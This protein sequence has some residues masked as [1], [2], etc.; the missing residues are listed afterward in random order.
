MPISVYPPNSEISYADT[1]GLDPFSRLRTSQP[2]GIFDYKQVDSRLS[3]QF[4]E[5]TAGS[6]SV[7]YQYDRSS[8]YLSVGTASGDRAL[9]QTVRYFPYVPGKGQQII[10]TGAFGAG[11]S[12]VD[13]YIGY[14]DDL[15]GLFFTMQGEALGITT[16]TSVS[17]SPADTFTASTSWNVDKLDGTGPSGLVIDAT[18]V[19]I[20]IIDFQWLG[21][22]RVRFSVDI[23]GVIVPVHEMLNANII[24]SVYM[25]TPSLPVRYEIIN[26]GVSASATTLEQICCSVASEGGYDIPGVEFSVG[27]G[28]TKR[29]V[30]A[31]APIF[32]VRLKSSF[33]AGEPNRR[34][35]RYLKIG[36]VASSSDAFVE[37]AHIHS[38]SSITATWSPVSADSA[39]EYSTDITAVTGNPE[40]VVDTFTAVSGLG[41]ASG[42][43]NLSSEFINAH[44]YI[45]QNFGS[46]NSQMFVVYATSYSGT[47][48]VS[49]G[50]GFI[51]FS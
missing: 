32:A 24:T 27:N 11:K 22:G 37:L 51:E 26:T 31:R 7:S 43:D 36:A 30:T 33:P 14:G 6:G 40:H 49:A 13:Q 44:S 41:S 1:P 46:N 50:I 9:R 19:Q 3:S 29:A 34:T 45:S 20:F 48:N 18:K 25:K 28:V 38:P 47:S 21:V 2:F 23:D 42:Q 12:N 4:E 8:S 17:G 39:V 5:V 15:N 10:M 35:A 16:R